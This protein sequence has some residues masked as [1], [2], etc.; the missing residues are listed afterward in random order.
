MDILDE[1]K[2]E[3]LLKISCNFTLKK[4]EIDSYE[5]FNYPKY[6]PLLRYYKKVQRLPS[7]NEER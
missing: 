1:L 5:K 7:T 4:Y 2:N 3:T 6:L